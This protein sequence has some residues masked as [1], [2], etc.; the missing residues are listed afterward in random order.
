MLQIIST[1]NYGGIELSGDNVDFEYLQKD[2]L[3]FLNL[4]EDFPGEDGSYHYL[5]GFYLKI[6]DMLQGLSG[7][8]FMLDNGL[9]DIEP[10]KTYFIAPKRNLYSAIRIAW[11]EAVF[12]MMIFQE[13]LSIGKRKGMVK[14]KFPICGSAYLY[15]DLLIQELR[16]ILSETKVN[17][18]LHR[19][20]DGKLYFE[21]FAIQY[22]DQITGEYLAM[23][24]QARLENLSLS[25]Y[26]VIEPK[27]DYRRFWKEVVEASMDQGCLMSELFVEL[28]LDEE[29]PW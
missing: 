14:D 16:R 12:L 27:K 28:D 1:K 26:R 3:Y 29:K 25:I 23:D 2:L 20:Y 11:P 9:E 17:R 6:E 19:I 8:R 18:L 5:A 15:T 24:K 10:E 7:R 4:L 13:A 22:L 21:A